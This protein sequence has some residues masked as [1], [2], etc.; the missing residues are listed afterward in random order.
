MVAV[1][2]FACD[3]TDTA[4][5]VMGVTV[6]RCTGRMNELPVILY[7]SA[8]GEDKA[9]ATARLRAL[10]VP[11]ALHLLEQDSNVNAILEKYNNGMRVTPTLVL[12]NEQVIFAEPTSEQLEARLSEA[13]YI[14][15]PSRAMEI[16]GAL[17]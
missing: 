6:V 13:G 1:A 7:G 11:F 5:V 9:L 2:L 16:R 8:T 17:K 14:F 12:G 3:S 15:S 10:N 4:V